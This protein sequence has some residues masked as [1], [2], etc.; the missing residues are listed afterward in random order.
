MPGERG[1]PIT[2]D[3]WLSMICCAVLSETWDLINA[4]PRRRR[5][6]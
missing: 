4:A 5:V 1:K 2:N 3:K 6:M